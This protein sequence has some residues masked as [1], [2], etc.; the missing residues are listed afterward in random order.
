MLLCDSWG[1][2]TSWVCAYRITTSNMDEEEK[3][4][5]K[6]LVKQLG[7]CYTAKMS[8]T[9]T[10]LIVDRAV[11]QKWENADAYSVLAVR[12]EWLVDTAVAGELPPAVLD[13][14]PVKASWHRLATLAAASHL[15]CYVAGLP[16]SNDSS[17]GSQ[18]DEMGIV[19]GGCCQSRNTCQMLPW[20]GSR[21]MLPSPSSLSSRR[22]GR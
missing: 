4:I 15:Y 14:M 16:D 19:Q 20:Q 22:G 8:R 9:N 6:E 17:Q 10:H 18:R 21:P 7:G 2:M 12:T 1:R 5:I 3:A 11:G 13:V